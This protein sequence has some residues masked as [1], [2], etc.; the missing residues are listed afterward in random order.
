MSS[1]E[2][3]RSLPVQPLWNDFQRKSAAPHREERMRGGAAQAVAY[4]EIEVAALPVGSEWSLSTQRRA[5]DFTLA[6]FG[7]VFFSPVFAVLAVAVRFSSPGPVVFRQE[8][9][10]RMG[11]LFTIYKFRT[12][13]ARR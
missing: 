4:D 2:T 11:Q 10:G 6:L 3:S 5:M 1:F 8:R 9:V 12:M 7:L 13:E